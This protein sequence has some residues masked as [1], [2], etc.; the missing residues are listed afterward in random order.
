MLY[1]FQDEEEM[2]ATTIVYLVLSFTQP[3]IDLVPQLARYDDLQKACEAASHTIYP[4]TIW[5]QQ[6][7]DRSRC[8]DDSFNSG[9]YRESCKHTPNGFELSL[10]P[11][12]EEEVQKMRCVAAPN[13]KLEAAKE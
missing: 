4:S 3:G 5:M 7:Y 2:I 8:C 13:F 6:I 12:R 11:L 9:E 1:S 10:C